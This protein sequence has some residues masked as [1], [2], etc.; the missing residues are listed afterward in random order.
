MLYPLEIRCSA[1]EGNEPVVCE[2]NEHDLPADDSSTPELR[3]DDKHPPSISD[4]PTLSPVTSEA[5][6][7]TSNDEDAP[8]VQSSKRASAM[9]ARECCRQWSAQLLEDDP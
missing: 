1:S 3:D 9:K 5:Q 2:N 7:I 8:G 4:S 6:Q